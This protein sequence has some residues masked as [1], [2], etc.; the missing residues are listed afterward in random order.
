M[1]NVCLQCYFQLVRLYQ[2]AYSLQYGLCDFDDHPQIKP[3]KNKIQCKV[4]AK[5]NHSL[6][7]IR[8]SQSFCFIFVNNISASPL[9]IYEP[10][11]KYLLGL[12]DTYRPTIPFPHKQIKCWFMSLQIQFL[13]AQLLQFYNYI[14]FTIFVYIT[15]IFFRCL[16]RLCF[17]K[18]RFYPLDCKLHIRLGSTELYGFDMEN[19]C[20]KTNW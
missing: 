12:H 15:D 10:V 9:S 19:K 5:K 11:I 18:K 1:Y 7:T 20:H 3:Y 4:V 16:S 2:R 14:G 8:R 6:N 13:L 17:E